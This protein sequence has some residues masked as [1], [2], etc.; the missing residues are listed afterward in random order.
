MTNRQT[1]MRDAKTTPG[2]SMLQRGTYNHVFHSRF[3]ANE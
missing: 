1:N 2:L 3:T